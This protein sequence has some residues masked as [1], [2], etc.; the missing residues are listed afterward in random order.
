MELF[1]K[2]ISGL[3]GIP[4][5]QISSTLRLLEE[6]ATIP[7][8]SRYRK[9]ATGGLDE[10]QIE[11]I[12]E[13]FEKLRD[14]SK[15]K[16]TIL[17]TI[18][19]QGKLTDELEKR[20]NDTWNPTELEDIYLPYKP[21]R[22]TR[23]EAARQKGLEP[24]AMIMMLQREN[25]LMAKAATF[26]KGE[27]K[28]VEDALKGAR[29]IIAEQV[30]EDERARNSIRNQFGR[31]AQI[32]A[33]VVKGKEEEA[34]KYQDYFD[35]SEPLKRCTSH[36]LL[37]IRRG[38]TEGL[39][40]VSISPDDEECIERLNRQFVHGNN[41]CSRQVS[42]A[43]AD[44]YKRLLKPSIE[45]EFAAQSKEKADEEAIRVFTE[46]LRQLLLS[47]PLGQK[48]VLAI[49]PGF[50]TGCKVVCLDAQG[51]LLHNENI[52]PHPPVNKTSEAASKLRK[53]VEAYQIEAI[54]I[55]NG[56]A[57]RETEDFI[58]QQSFDRQIPVFV[59]SEQGASIYSASK[60]ARDEFPD[61]DV[62]VRGAVS[63]GRRLMDPLAELVKI[64]PKSIGVGQY[65]HD[66]DQNKLKKALDQTVENCVNLVGVNLN[67]ASSHLL[68]YISGLGPQLAQN[69]VNYRAENG[70][71]SSRK[72]LMKVPRMGAKAFEQCAGF[73]RIPTAKNPLDN[74][75][76]HPES[77]HI[78]EQM[79]KD[80]NCTVDQLIA[81][82]ELRQKIRISDYITPTVGLPTLQD[83]LQELDKPGRDPRKA[84]KVFEFDKNVRT[85]ADLREGM[86]LPG[87]V[88]NITNFGAF[89]DIG[90]KENGLVHLSQL[91][92]RF[93]TDPT[94]I[95]SIHQHVM[96]RIMNV[97]TTRK[98]IQLSMIGVPQD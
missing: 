14:I 64:D 68:T 77:Y 24:L 74:T 87:I 6:G 18:S 69:I 17:S 16:E 10:V 35:F 21:K 83:I 15:R 11:Q 96:V 7:F 61:Y 62:T 8:I 19:E 66:V 2:M 40:K 76:V 54:S 89:V 56:T 85:I 59:V 95:V 88:G 44:A 46:N 58:N 81:E 60:I 70:A 63:I 92:E 26:V 91:A 39:L 31:Q 33:K 43:T 65:Q 67:T 45:T 22:K 34:A 1:H 20:I 32:T 55:G 30:N 94:E 86:I 49:D 5:R 41:E 71:F 4:E 50:R 57:S 13:Q 38:E 84:I 3:L 75:A 53:M 79:A 73:L 52:Y 36:R 42:E 23:A 97:D 28:D 25:N 82:K 78:V 37:A 93:I 12:K 29:D 98:R 48:R 9:E 80:L 51:N 47:P 72:E 27:V 90:I